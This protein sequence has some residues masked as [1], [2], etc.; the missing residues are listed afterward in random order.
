MPYPPTNWKDL[1][2]KETPINADNLNKLEQAVALASEPVSYNDL[3]NKPTLLTIGT[4]ATTAKAGNYTPPSVTTSVNG[5]ML[6]ADK[7]KL[8]NLVSGAFTPVD[9]PVIDIT[10]PTDAEQVQGEIQK[11]IDAVKSTGLFK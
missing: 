5:L 1:P 2:S 6:A 9:A 11:F 3:T 4:S 7:V 10:E 8:D